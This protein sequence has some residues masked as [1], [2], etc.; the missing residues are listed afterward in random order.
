[1]PRSPLALAAL[2][3]VAVPGLDAFDVRR[4]AHP[5]AGVD[6]AVVIDASGGR[7]V[8]RAPTTAAAGAAL[9]AEVAL[10][11]ALAVQVD[12]DRLPFDVPRPVGFAQLPEGG[13]AVVHPQLA[14]RPLRLDALGPGPGLAAELGRA[15]AALHELPTSTV[16]DAGLP[17]YDAESYR[18]R[19][20]SEVDEAARTGR[21]P[22]ALLRRWESALEDVALW[23]FHPTV[24]HG[25]LSADHVLCWSG[26]P[27]GI[28]GWAE[29][30]VAD[31][32]DDLA[33]LL[34]AAPHEAVDPI[35]EAYSLRRTELTDRHLVDRALLAGELAL[36]R[37]LLF[38]VRNQDQTVIDDAVEMLVD[39][40]ARLAEELA[41]A[42]LLAEEEAAADL[43]EHGSPSGSDTFGTDPG[44]PDTSS[45]P[46]GP[47]SPTDAGEPGDRVEPADQ[48]EPTDQVDPGDPTD[49]AGSVDRGEGL[50]PPLTR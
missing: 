24:V 2:A 9:E 3:T 32:A 47:R 46:G 8:V 48:V 35:L 40:D 20:L 1:M 31:P 29:A 22:A 15:I 17:V 30:K 10:L 37:W 28:L 18:R 41:A 50:E 26:R 43:E 5:G 38:G 6:T 45:D 16:E 34:V 23:R 49:Q 42:E 13:R 19:R 25:D 27:T 7:W 4:P 11:E 12:A 33:W 14:G 21:V 39:L 44:E 36:A